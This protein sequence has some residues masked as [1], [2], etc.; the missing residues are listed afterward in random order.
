MKIAYFDCSSGISGDMCLG[1]LIDAG[2]PAAKLEKELRKLR[3]KGYSLKVERV[4]RSGFTATK[5][6]VQQPAV[7]SQQSA[8]R[9][10]DVER[11]IRTSSLSEEVK[12]KG[13]SIFR[14]LFTAEAKVHGET[15]NAAHLHE[16][17]AVDCMVDIFGTVI[18]LNLL[19]I[20]KVYT[21]GVNIGGGSVRT[22]HGIL[23][24]PAPATAELLKDIPVYSDGINYELTTPTGAVL[25][26]EISS[27]FGSIPD[28]VIEK[29]GIG[30]GNKNFR[31]KPNV[32]R[33][34]IGQGKEQS[35][36]NRKQ[37]V[38][39]IETT[40]DDMNPQIYE[41]VM[42]SLFKAGALDVYLTQLIMKKGRPGIKLTVL[43]NSK[44]KEKMMK[45]IFEETTTIG[46]RFYEADRQTLKREIK[47]INTALGKVKVK[48]SKLGSR[49]IKTTPEYEDCKK[50]AKKLTMPLTEVMKKISSQS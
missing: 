17:G 25:L 41:C 12:Q 21:S 37:K 35:A 47:E 5:I 8:K 11:I 28:M 2:V 16:L 1:A 13:L 7:S 34:L 19:G 50:L 15:F 31:N 32:L 20:E 30:A 48:I 24:V 40:I 27:S 10:K 23:P 3:V 38:A 44:E 22:K 43:C 29:I 42:E 9:W 49:I 46:L 4:K 26:K 36:E 6:N 39:V 33:I 18:G 45:I 14:R